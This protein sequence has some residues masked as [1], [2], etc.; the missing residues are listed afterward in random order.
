[1][2][3][4][5]SRAVLLLMVGVLVFQAGCQSGAAGASFL[6]LFGLSQK[7]V[8][9]ALVVERGVLDPFKP[10]E[11]LRQAMSEA[12]KRPV[13]LD[14]C[15]PIQL[16]PN[17][18]LGFY[19]FACITPGCYIEMNNRERFEVIA[20]AADEA[21]RVTRS[22]LL[23]VPID[24]EIKR[25]EDLRGKTVAFGPRGDARTHL[26]AMALLRDHG[27]VK[28][29]LS[30][31]VLPVPGSLKHFP[32]MRDIAQ[33]VIN[34]SSDAGFIDEAAFEMFPESAAPEGEP[35]RDKL[36]VI[37]RTMPVPQKL[38]IRSPKVATDVANEVTDFLLTADRNH[39][40]AL[41]PLLFSAYRP[42]SEQVLASCERLA[43]TNTPTSAPASEEQE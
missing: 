24:S 23:V 16:E 4:Q 42:A 41:R 38:V 37:A 12:I 31:E 30:L 27:L 10:H 40:D 22:A 6:S 35:T 43:E 26:A 25:V 15:L 3:H 20:V 36:R 8:V 21:G 19:Q 1:M 29:D 33:S 11:K 32:Q 2:H 18:N 39:P 34:H 7:P 13:R 5:M 17:L 9:M 28:T 14:L